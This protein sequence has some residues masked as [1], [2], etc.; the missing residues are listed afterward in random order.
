MTDLRA[1]DRIGGFVIV[2]ELGAGGMGVVFLARDE[3][4]DRD[5]ALKV[6][7]WADPKLLA[8]ARLAASLEHPA[9]VPVYA[10]GEDGGRLYLAMRY[11]PD[12]TLAQRLAVARLDPPPVMRLLAAIADALDVAHGAG[13]VHRDVKPANILLDGD[14]AQLAD[15]G[16][17][18]HS[19]SLADSLRA[20]SLMGTIGYV[21][22]E[23]IEGDRVDGRAD[24]YGLACVAFEC[25]TGRAPFVRDSDLATIYAHLSDPVPRASALTTLPAGVDDVLAR[26]LA[27][28]PADRFASCAA[29]VAALEAALGGMADGGSRPGGPTADTAPE[30]RRKLATVVFCDLS[31][32]TELSEQL[33]VEPLRELS[34]RYYAEMRSAVAAHG[35]TVEK[36]AG[37]SVVALFGIPTAHEDD[38]LRAIRAAIDMRRRVAALD[39][40]YGRRFGVRLEVHI[41]LATGEV[42][43]GPAGEDEPLATGVTLNLGKRLEETAPSGEILIGE[44][45]WRLTR[46]AVAVEP[47]AKLVLR[48]ISRPV[49]AYRVL[50]LA[51]EVAAPPSRLR[52]ELVG[53]GPQLAALGELYRAC[54]ESGKA[55]TAAL[56][57]EPGAGKTRLVH[58][59][60]QTAAGATVLTGRCLSYGE[61]I[62]YWPLGEA[63]RQAAAGTAHDTPGRMRELIG[64][65]VPEEPAAAEFLAVAA[66]ASP[67]VASPEEIAWATRTLLARLA[68]SAPVI[69]VLD[70]LQWA[71]P[72]FLQLLGNIGAIDAPVLLLCLART[73]IADQPAWRD[74]EGGRTQLAVDR[75]T[76]QEAAELI[77]GLLSSR[78]GGDLV[79]R[80]TEAAGGNPLFL[81]ELCEMLIDTGEVALAG[82]GWL[83]RAD[84]LSERLPVTLDTLIRSR[85]DL[86]PDAER[87]AIEHASVEGTV[88]TREALTALV[89]AAMR[90]RMPSAI[91]GLVRR[92]LARPTT[93][94]GAPAFR[95]RHVLVRDVAYRGIAKARRADAHEQFA[96]WVERASPERASEFVEIVGY[97]LEQACRYRAEL[98]GTGPDVRALGADA[99]TWLVRAAGRAR[100]R[101]DGAAAVRLLRRA[102]AVL[103]D[104]AQHGR[105][106]VELGATLTDGG[107][108]SEARAALSEA[109]ALAASLGDAALGAR[110]VVEELVVELQSDPAAAIV[111]AGEALA[112]SEAVFAQVADDEGL[113]RLSYLN[114]LINWIQG[115]VADA[116]EA[117]ARAADLA[118]RSGD[119][120][121]LSDVLR[122]IP[123]A[124][125]FGPMPVA[126]AI[127]RC[128]QVLAELPGSRLTEAQI[129]GPMGGLV[130]MQ[131]D[132]DGARALLARR[133]A[134]IADVGFAMHAV[135]EWA[136]QVELL[137]GDPQAA[138]TR[139]REGYAQLEAIGDRAFLSTTAGLLARALHEQGRDEQALAFTVICEETAAPGDLAAQIAWRGSRARILAA[140]GETGGA[141]TLAQEAVAL[142]ERTDLL[143]DHGDALLDLTE[144]LRADGRPVD[145]ANAAR[146]A[147]TLYRTKGNLVAADR[148]RSVLHELVPAD[149]H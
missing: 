125:L 11:V 73:E 35:G 102:A 24:Q 100:V 110:L 68:R 82:E 69:F 1:G 2:R 128:E 143:S 45:T 138:E 7:G 20:G 142:A 76:D 71:E 93:V 101:G 36:F 32:S 133:D 139:L 145:A 95:F 144:A 136:A 70:D 43:A 33:D 75:L 126:D 107:H 40:E 88:F 49:Q 53:R 62:T 19:G 127:R 111:R 94:E 140:R 123:S 44:V 41:G 114:A 141:V 105:I 67:A 80:L 137:A 129:L 108:L 90:D 112:A 131:G 27:K 72:A 84:A 15:F 9:I 17:A 3:T 99:A 47:V 18:R 119:T 109:G 103:P 58:E 39:A 65:L 25:L 122:W 37:D 29:F 135:G 31:R 132:F 148:A 121:R 34:L 38:A 10:A 98:G 89:P 21:A 51:D 81:E 26:G 50:G 86:L 61:A 87:M 13:L 130:A 113:C 147:E 118:R 116:E 55:R 149:H 5:L 63:I 78:V 92:D 64:A 16:L 85:L 66:G 74:G 96:R 106:L 83:P 12:G 77:G 4:L 104:D 8:E 59:F 42:A 79:A 28:R 120:G 6:L 57:G 91:D 14:R 97:H 56:L 48:G 30:A 115:R 52:S 117:W 23:Q 54:L 22:P 146:S 46:D 134:I 60:L 124:A